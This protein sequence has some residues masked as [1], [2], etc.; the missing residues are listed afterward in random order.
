MAL[1]MDSSGFSWLDV[2]SLSGAGTFEYQNV[3]MTYII[4]EHKQYDNLKYF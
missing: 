4:K 2:Y 3:K 1:S